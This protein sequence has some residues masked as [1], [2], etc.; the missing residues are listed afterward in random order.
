M[1]NL[2]TIDE[3]KSIEQVANALDEWKDGSVPSELKMVGHHA[4]LIVMVQKQMDDV[5]VTLLGGIP[6][7]GKLVSEKF[8]E[9]LKQAKLVD[10]LFEKDPDAG[11]FEDARLRGFAREVVEKLHDI[12]KIARKERKRRI[13]K[14][15]SAFIYALVFFLAALLAIFSYLGW[16]DQ[17]KAFIYNI[18]S[19]K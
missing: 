5:V 8:G 9:V 13:F 7:V 10:S 11:Y 15:T 1:M 17:F 6:E 16:L 19:P 4:Q 12:A 18:L 3:I 2:L 14:K